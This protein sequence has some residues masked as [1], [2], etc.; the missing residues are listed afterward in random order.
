MP[1]SAFSDPVFAAQSTF[2]AVLDA[3]ARPGEIRP[4]P[5]DASA[6]E[7]MTTAMAALALTLF[8]QDTPVWLD[9]P[10][11]A[12]P[13][14]SDWIRFH[15]AAPIVAEPARCAFALVRDSLRLPALGNFD[16]GTPEYPDRSTTLILHVESL[17][18]GPALELSGPG[19]DGRRG[20]SAG[21]LPEDIAARL[22][23]NRA[24]FPRGVDLLLV[25]ND[26]VAA[27]PRSVNVLNRGA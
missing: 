27:L 1:G 6:P 9:P 25:S 18:T 12:E 2:R 13:G 7:P 4:M 17:I 11:A 22:M 16:V 21:P 23:A 5:A 26:S 10:F 19:I 24:L 3:I 8:D 20:F 14:V 15:T